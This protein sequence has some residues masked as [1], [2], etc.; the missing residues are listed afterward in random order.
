[1]H[2]HPAAVVCADEGGDTL[3]QLVARRRSPIALLDF[4]AQCKQIA[5]EG[6]G[7]RAQLRAG[8]PFEE[9]DRRR[10]QLDPI[11][12][13]IQQSRLAYPGLADD[14][15]DAGLAILYRGVEEFLQ[16]LQL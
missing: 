4:K 1:M 13:L 5:D 16:L 14:R 12:E 10:Q 7:R 8:A 9:P 6:V 15:D 2:S 11:V 3:L